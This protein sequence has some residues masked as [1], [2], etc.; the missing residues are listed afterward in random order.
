LIPGAS[1][2]QIDR[3]GGG[4]NNQFNANIFKIP[5]GMAGYEDSTTQNQ[6]T[7][8]LGNIPRDAGRGPDFAQFDFSVI[9]RTPLVHSLSTEFRADIFNIAN[10]PNFASPDGNLF[11]ANPGFN[12]T[13]PVAP[14]NEPYLIDPSFGRSTSTIGSLIGTG[15]SRQIQLAV[16]LL[17]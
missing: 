9:K 12:G 15:T 16:K 3:K 10:H 17:F 14:G 2:S 4:P 8:S 7:S 5:F 11:I 13:L 6:G 1:T